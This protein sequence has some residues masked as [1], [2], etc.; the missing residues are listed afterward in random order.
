MSLS[1]AN[2]RLVFPAATVVL[3][4]A[5]CDTRPLDSE[6]QAESETE[7]T[8]QWI[9]TYSFWFGDCDFMDTVA[10][11]LSEAEIEFSRGENGSIVYAQTSGDTVNGIADA[12]HAERRARG[13][14]QGSTECDSGDNE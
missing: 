5:G 9:P 1:S 14:E 10:A 6:P 2:S 8:T 12:I 3:S 13:W 7:A 4:L 11:A